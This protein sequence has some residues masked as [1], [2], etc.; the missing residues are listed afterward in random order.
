M[1]TSFSP[2]GPFNGMAST[3]SCLFVLLI[4]F[5][6][7]LTAW[8]R[9]ES[10]SQALF[11]RRKERVG[12]NSFLNNFWLKFLVVVGIGREI[13]YSGRVA[14]QFLIFLRLQP[15]FLAC[16]C[17]FT[18]VTE[19]SCPSLKFPPSYEKTEVIVYTSYYKRKQISV[20]PD[21]QEKIWRPWISVKILWPPKILWPHMHPHAPHA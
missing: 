2:F 18:C 6:L 5:L 1:L 14:L 7:I 8:L 19:C 21:F 3:F 16:I 4:C 13:T 9:E 10:C 12:I 20:P 17:G 11:R 15:R